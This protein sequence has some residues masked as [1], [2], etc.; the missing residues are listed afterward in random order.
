MKAISALPIRAVPELPFVGA[1]CRSWGG[2]AL[3]N[4]VVRQ[5]SWVRTPVIAW[6]L[7][8]HQEIGRPQEGKMPLNFHGAEPFFDPVEKVICWHGDDGLRTVLCKVTRS[9]IDDL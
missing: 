3:A 5:Q 6:G 2:L 8:Q 7:W 9:A 1:R 4:A